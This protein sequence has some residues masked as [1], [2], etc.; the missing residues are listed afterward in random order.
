MIRLVVAAGVVGL[1]LGFF[2]FRLPAVV[3]A[4]AG[5][6]WACIGMSLA[7]EWTVM[8]SIGLAFGVVTILQ[9]GYLAGLF[10]VSMWGRAKVPAPILRSRHIDQWKT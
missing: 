10:A 1:V 5:L 4:S 2:L 3:T 6:F 8:S 7:A 9:C